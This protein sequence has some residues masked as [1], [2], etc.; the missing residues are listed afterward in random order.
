MNPNPLDELK[1]VLSPA[2]N[3]AASTNLLNTPISA[4]PLQTMGQLAASPAVSAKPRPQP[5]LDHVNF[6]LLEQVMNNWGVMAQMG[7]TPEDVLKSD[8]WLN[9]AGKLRPGDKVHIRAEDMSWYLTVMVMQAE[10]KFATVE[11][12]ELYRFANN[13][14]DSG[15]QGDLII[16]WKGGP[17]MHIIQRRSTGQ[18]VKEGFRVRSDAMM[19]MA[20]HLKE[21]EQKG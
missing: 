13:G 20:M 2:A 11:K 6:S 8:Y 7:T 12:L 10:P 21:I 9:V 1:Q 5:R 3:M 15:P 17:A 18:V 19:W 4:E 14:D 16:K